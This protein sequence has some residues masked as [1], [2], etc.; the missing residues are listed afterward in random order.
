[1][2][3]GPVMSAQTGA[4][5]QSRHTGSQLMFGTDYNYAVRDLSKAVQQL[6]EAG[7]LNSA[8]LRAVGRENA[9]R[10]FPRFKA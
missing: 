1:M 4:I 10:L 3:L 6:Q 9:L 2:L 8:E 7:E 5:G